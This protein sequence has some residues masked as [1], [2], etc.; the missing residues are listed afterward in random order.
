[1]AANNVRPDME[2]SAPVSGGMRWRS[3][4][5][6]RLERYGR[7]PRYIFDNPVEMLEEECREREPGAILAPRIAGAPPTKAM[8]GDMYV[9]QAR[10]SDGVVDGFTWYLE[11]CPP[12]MVVDRHTGKVSWTPF[13]GGYAEVVLC[14]RSLYGAVGRQSWT[15]SVR[16]AAAVR[17]FVANARFLA[18]LRRKAIANANAE[19]VRPARS[20]HDLQDV[21][22]LPLFLRRCRYTGPALRAP[23]FPGERSRFAVPLRM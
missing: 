19:A 13:E 5:H 10:A 1:M 20:P 14:A 18:A 17:I 21:P 11:E 6:D 9:Y 2:A 8:A 12:G 15:V 22:L 23:P 16:K 4:Y 7:P 3:D